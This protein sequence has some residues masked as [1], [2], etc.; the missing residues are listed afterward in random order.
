[1]RIL[2]LTPQLPYPPQQGTS[3]RNYNLLRYLAGRHEV[4]LLSFALP[5]T[6]PEH[7]AHLQGF[8]RA[9]A[10]V[11]APSRSTARRLLTLVTSSRPDMAWRLYSPAY[12]QALASLVSR[13][14]FDVLQV[15]GIE[16]APY[17]PSTGVGDGLHGLASQRQQVIRSTRSGSPL[18]APLVVFDDHNAE[19][20]L[21]QR[22]CAT[23]LR[24][25]RRWVAAAYSFVQWLK[26]RRFE[27]DVCRRADRLV[28]VSDADAA[29]LAAL[30]PHLRATVVPNGVD[31]AA[32][33]PAIPPLAG[34]ARPSLVFTGKMDFRPNID[35]V[36]WFAGEVL[37]RLWQAVPEAHL[38]VVGQSPSPRLDPLRAEPRITITGWV[39]DV[40]PY[41]AGADVYVVPLRVGG[42][43]RLK[44]LEA[45]AM[46]RAL[47][48]TPLGVEGLGAGDGQELVLAG[49]AQ[50]F[51]REIAALLADAGRRQALGRAARA[52]VERSYGWDAIGPRLEAVYG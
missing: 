15:E 49:E 39:D 17:M 1:M 38:Y 31:L 11:P 30:D 37:P 52:F 7:I 10:T 43:T 47:V 26:L 19:Y 46:G 41:I 14:R 48:A 33:H 8:C 16:M 9:V 29:A 6:A 36:L 23:D 42:G 50:A 22:A 27:R 25:P 45:M 40:R 28:A 18:T 32:Y 13:E 44:V 35:A 4:S 20:L 12:T 24:R 2:L 34:L 3:L 51:A 5:G 21:Q